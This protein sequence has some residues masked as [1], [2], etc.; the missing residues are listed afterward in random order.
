MTRDHAQ[1]TRPARPR[2]RL[3]QGVVLAAHVV[4]VVVTDWEADSEVAMEAA[5]ARMVVRMEGEVAKA[6]MEVSQASGTVD[7]G[8]LAA[9]GVA[10]AADVEAVV[11]RKEGILGRRRISLL[12]ST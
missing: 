6:A 8:V 11:E 9:V 12:S 5:L 4:R 3:V 7:M 2:A 10:A 1:K